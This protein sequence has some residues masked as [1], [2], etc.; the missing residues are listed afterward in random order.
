MRK[1]L[2]V[3]ALMVSIIII[4]GCAAAPPP[5]TQVQ[6]EID[7]EYQ[8]I[9]VRYYG[10]LILEGARTHVVARGE[11]LSV[12]A[13]NYYNN[14]YH[15]PLIMLASRQVVSDP[16]RISPGMRLT[17]PD[18]ARNWGNA[19][20]RNRLKAYYNEIADLY[21]RKGQVEAAQNIR[22]LAASM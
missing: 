4:L 8:E 19:G 7:A 3:L 2:F 15:F 16:E 10:D 9:Y 18:L 12:I 17:I 1:L 6:Q 22:N 13:R 11:T 20:T 5:Q 14:K 21:E